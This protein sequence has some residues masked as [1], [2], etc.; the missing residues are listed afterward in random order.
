MS[1]KSFLTNQEIKELQL[2]EAQ[3]QRSQKRTAEQIEAIYTQGSNILVSAS[4][5]SGKTFVMVERIISQILCGISVDRLFISTFTVKAAGELKER[6]EKKLREALQE[7]DDKALKQYLSEQLSSL[8]VAD[9]GTMDAFTQQI[10]NRYGYILGIAPNYRIIQDKS[11]QDI[12]KD[13]VFSDLFSDYSQGRQAHL[14]RK[15]VKNFSGYRK[16]LQAFKQVVYQIHAFSQ[17]TSNPKKWLQNVFLKGAQTYTDTDSVPK[18]FISNLLA[19]MQE[20]ADSLRDVTELEDYK[21]YTSK[22]KLTA[23]YQKHLRI[24]ENL[25]DWAL[26]FAENY[27]KGSLSD[28]IGDVTDLLPAGSAVTV[29]GRKYPVFKN[30]H[31]RLNSFR[32]LETVLSYQA[33]SLPLL[34]L[35]QAF[36]LDFSQQY[37]QAKIQESVFEFTD[38][39]HFAI[40]ILEEN[41]TIRHAYQDK[42]YEVMVDEYQDTNHMQERLLELLSNGRNRFMVGDMKQ[43]IYRFRQADPQIFNQKFKDFQENPDA[44]RLIILKENFRNHVNVLASVNSLFSHLMDEQIGDIL[45][46]KNHKLVAGSAGQ[47][48]LHPQNE[49]EF[50]IYDTDSQTQAEEELSDDLISPGEVKLVAQEIIRLHNEQGVAFEDISLLVAARTRNDD[51]VQTF[52]KFGIPLVADGGEQNYLKSVEVMVMLDTLRSID[53]PLND[54][55]LVALLRSPMFAFDEDELA[56]LSLQTLKDGH[57]QN[58]YEKIENVFVRRGQHMELIHPE[59]QMKVEAFLKV[60]RSWRDFARLH[61]LYDLIWKIYNDC[62]YYDYVASSPN[63][64]QAQANLYALALRADQFEKNGFKGLSRFITMIDRI[65]ETDNDLADVE[66]AAPKQAVNLMTIHKSKGLEFKYVFLLNMDKKFSPA[67]SRSPIILSRQ[68]G[69]GIKYTA[70]MKQELEES[71]LPSVRV[72]METL[73]YQINQQELKL[74]ALSEQ[75]RLLYVAMTRAE[76]KLYLVGKGSQEKWDSR[77]SADSPQGQFL[78]VSDREQATSFQDWV[79]AVQAAYSQEDLHLKIR[80]ITDEDLKTEPI[81]RL[82][83]PSSDLISKK[84]ESN[85]LEELQQA[86][87]MLENVEQVNERYEAAITLPTVRTPSQIKKLYEP[88]LDR[89]GVAVADSLYQSSPA[90]KL[91]NFSQRQKADAA[92]LGSAVHELLQRLPLSKKVTMSDITASMAELNADQAVKDSIQVDKILA[93]FEQTELGQLIQKNAD[94]VHR[95]APFA[96][97]KDDPAS[98]EKFVVRGIIDGYILLSDRLVLFDYKTDK[99]TNPQTIKQRYQGQ[100]ALYAEAL[101]RS[102]S[103]ECVDQYLVLLGGEKLEVLK[104]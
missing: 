76:Q 89:E 45:Y 87:A 98:Q 77:W 91:P 93:F 42:Y 88:V 19:A 100:M 82:Q 48:L 26:H 41:E 99:F 47:Q 62:F 65:L 29:A 56:R 54:Y 22:G 59:L 33:E 84:A 64:R 46:D 50:L 8:P 11:E 17:S 78:P 69:A 58:F 9:I 36:V 104:L 15:L 1:F 80:F 2:R 75:M 12:L 68:N 24:I 92:V 57:Q 10:L 61:L 90:F 44:G 67:D 7:T 74:A 63:G 85:R 4:A 55:A 66:V 3:S 53:N 96:M 20:A 43:S 13:E 27:G 95:E 52:N 18:L 35:L 94:K 60:F 23:A 73:P 72:R 83:N 34:E 51:I 38:I 102:Y 49:T 97:L 21:K 6:L 31:S 81:G 14:F 79:L 39:A 86:L 71:S 5:G 103:M 28:F 40:A 25:S 30:L 70:D 16:D 37:L 101:S 32:H